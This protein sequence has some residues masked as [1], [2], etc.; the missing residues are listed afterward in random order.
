VSLTPLIELR[1]RHVLLALHS[2]NAT[3]PL[4]AKNMT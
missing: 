3:V 2:N 1:C 4:L